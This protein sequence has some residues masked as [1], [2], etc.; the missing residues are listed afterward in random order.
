VP[1]PPP[2]V[3]LLEDQDELGRVI[4][5]V[6]GGEGLEVV[7]AKDA[8]AALDTIRDREVAFVVSDL[9]SLGIERG[10]PLAPIAEPHPDLP[11]IIIRDPR[12]DDVPFFGPWREEGSRVLLRRPFRIDDLLSATRE[13]V[14]SSAG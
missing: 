6:L 7:H 13:L 1:P 5:D 9:P 2:V 12:A 8:T 4:G 14:Q 11:I 10:D 3:V